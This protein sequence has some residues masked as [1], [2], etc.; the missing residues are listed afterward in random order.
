MSVKQLE[1]FRRRLEDFIDKFSPMFE[2][3]YRFQLDTLKGATQGEFERELDPATI[4][5]SNI[6]NYVW[7]FS[8]GMMAISELL[9][10]AD[11]D[12]ISFSG[13]DSPIMRLG[14]CPL[15]GTFNVDISRVLK[16]SE[17]QC[18]EMNKRAVLMHVKVCTD[19]SFAICRELVV[20]EDFERPEIRHFDWHH[21]MMRSSEEKRK[22]FLDFIREAQEDEGESIQMHIDEEKVAK[23]KGEMEKM[24]CGMVEGEDKKEKTKKVIGITVDKLKETDIRRVISSMMNMG[25]KENEDFI[26]KIMEET[27]NALEAE[28]KTEEE[29]SSVNDLGLELMEEMAKQDNQFG[30]LVGAFM[31]DIKRKMEKGQ[32]K[33]DE[34]HVALEEDFE[35]AYNQKVVLDRVS[36]VMHMNSNLLGGTATQKKKSTNRKKNRKKK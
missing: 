10:E 8:Q 11:I 34:V 4:H 3:F 6:F 12:K 25:V 21:L 20:K 15:E 31:K 23:I 7:F 36:E 30:R 19:L 16:A 1:K 29:I 35:E 5:T 26:T 9:H 17:E 28:L 33:K 27:K 2:G 24:L 32:E 22:Q 13:E 18:S 14:A